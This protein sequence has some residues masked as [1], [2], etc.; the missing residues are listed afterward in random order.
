MRFGL[1][2]ATATLGLWANIAG[3]TRFP[4]P[5]RL[6]AHH[7]NLIADCESPQATRHTWRASQKSRS[8]AASGGTAEMC[9]LRKRPK[10]ISHL[11]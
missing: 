7:G 5:L 11:G 8:K 9:R 3:L 4:V 10:T 2:F 6:K 1:P